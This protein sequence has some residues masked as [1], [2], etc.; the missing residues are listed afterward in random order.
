MVGL[1]KA[2]EILGN[3]GW[4]AAQPVAFREEVLRRAGLMRFEPGDLIYSAGDPP[5]GVYGLVKGA[6]SV[7]AGPLSAIPRLGH[8]GL[9]G[10]WIGIGGYISR[11]Q[12]RIGMRATIETWMMCL[13][14]DVMDQMEANDPQATRRFAQILMGDFDTVLQA[15][16]SLQKMS[17]DK[18][19]AA[20]LHRIALEGVAIPL[21][22]TELGEIS[23]TSRKHTN[24]ALHRFE[25]SG[26]LKRGY[27][28]ITICN[29]NALRSFAEHDDIG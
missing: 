14:L 8:I 3:L 27:R 15:F 1:V 6:V 28:S 2:R 25:A 20:T 29:V 11:G 22:Q 4:L 17:A 13:P 26:W 23:N 16:L 12:R 18:R 5:G 19:V 24:A 10:S 21:S 9:P 7:T